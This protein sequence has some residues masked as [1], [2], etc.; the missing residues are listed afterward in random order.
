MMKAIFTTLLIIIVHVATYAQESYDISK[1]IDK[2]ASIT[3][4]EILD[5]G[6]DDYVFFRIEHGA[7]AFKQK[8]Y[9]MRV[10]RV[11]LEVEEKVELLKNTSIELD[12]FYE[13]LYVG[14]KCIYLTNFTTDKKAK[15]ID[16]Y[17]S[18]LDES[19]ENT[20]MPIK[21]FTG[22]KPRS[23]GNVAF[24]TNTDMD[25]NFGGAIVFLQNESRDLIVIKYTE[26]QKRGKEK[27]DVYHCRV[28]DKNLKEIYKTSYEEAAKVR[29]PQFTYFDFDYLA[30]DDGI[31]SID[32]QDKFTLKIVNVK[33]TLDHTV[34]LKKDKVHSIK[35][36]KIIANGNM[37]VCGA[38]QSAEGEHEEGVF[39][40][41]IDL[42]TNTRISYDRLKMV[43]INKRKKPRVSDALI[44]DDGNVFFRSCYTLPSSSSPPMESD[45]AVYFI[46]YH[47][48]SWRKDI[49]IPTQKSGSL[50]YPQTIKQ[51]VFLEGNS[52]CVL[53]N[54]NEK[55]QL[56]E[57]NKY[58]LGD[59]IGSVTLSSPSGR[60]SM[61]KVDD[62]GKVKRKSFLIETGEYLIGYSCN[63]GYDLYTPCRK[64]SGVVYGKARV[65]KVDFSKF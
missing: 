28:F 6:F 54:D 34:A 61:L 9:F 55:A 42:K 62:K 25:L 12:K 63:V 22:P 7:T 64:K 36:V 57:P 32:P 17:C 24:R 16:F 14:P 10:N 29:L 44:S 60:I 47:G 3:H 38:Y 46:S 20:K 15:T 58:T 41:E 13:A 33:K 39:R 48:E 5:P 31:V 56:I 26:F 8:D 2:T 23:S 27:I 65:I 51:R 11:S 52:L 19:F 53:Y 1:Q 35:K 45:H 50:Q 59:K 49:P 40:A 37:I 18:K 30:W 4:A 43:E 21:L